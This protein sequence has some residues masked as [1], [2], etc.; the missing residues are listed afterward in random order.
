L[1]RSN[2]WIGHQHRLEAIGRFAPCTAEVAE[3][4]GKPDK[5]FDWV[6]LRKSL[7]ETT[8]RH[9]TTVRDAAHVVC[10][11]PKKLAVSQI[12]KHHDEGSEIR[13]AENAG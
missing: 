13:A 10:S 3:D 4:D 6:Y 7:L 1:I 5:A 9:S 12:W 11:R 2:V 8:A